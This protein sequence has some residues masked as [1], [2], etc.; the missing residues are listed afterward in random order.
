MTRPTVSVVIPTRDRWPIL[1]R[2]LASALGQEAVAVEVVLV[3]DGS[4]EPAPA[5]VTGIADSRVRLLRH[6]ASRGVARARNRGLE[7]AT[8]RWVA[9]LDDDDLWAPDKLAVQVR[10]A[11]ERDA[12]LAYTG[13]LWV[14][15]RGTVLEA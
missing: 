9:F 8:G 4:R 11:G 2:A 3:D 5:W 13:V 14:D 1:G 7:E 6:E 10:A 12:V 15:E